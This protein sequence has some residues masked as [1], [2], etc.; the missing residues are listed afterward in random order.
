MFYIHEEN[1]E[2]ESMMWSG[3]DERQNC[4]ETDDVQVKK[5]YPRYSY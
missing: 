4:K 2:I 1:R 5:G 3:V